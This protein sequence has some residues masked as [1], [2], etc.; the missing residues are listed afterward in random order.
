MSSYIFLLYKYSFDIRSLFRDVSAHYK[1][2]IHAGFFSTV[3]I[4]LWVAAFTICI[5]TISLLYKNKRKN[6]F[7]ISFYKYASFLNFLL[8]LDDQFL[9]HERGGND[10]FFYSVYL[11]I[12]IL[13]ISKLKN[14]ILKKETFYFVFALFFFFGSI[15]IDLNFLNLFNIYWVKNILEDILKFIG[16]CYWLIFFGTIS[17]RILSEE[18]NF[19][20]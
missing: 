9:L 12:T 14:I 1:I 11:V 16:I 2:P 15:I 19:R 10:I 4:F 7:K 5:V 8:L 13:L 3:G 17:L 18:I 20:S 6:K